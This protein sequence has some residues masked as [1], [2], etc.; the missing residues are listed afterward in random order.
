[1]FLLSMR[2]LKEVTLYMDDKKKKFIAPEADV[3]DYANDDII[4]L[5]SNDTAQ[6]GDGAEWWME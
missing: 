6:W 1:M 5:S 3:L 4:T 2:L